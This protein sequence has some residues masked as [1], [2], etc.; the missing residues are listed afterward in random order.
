MNSAVSNSWNSASKAVKDFDEKYEIS[1]K[2][3]QGK[4]KIVSEWKSLWK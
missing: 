1:K 2:A 4:D 3:S